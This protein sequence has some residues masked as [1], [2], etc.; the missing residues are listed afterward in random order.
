MENTSP[1]VSVFSL[2]FGFLERRESFKDML[3]LERISPHYLKATLQSFP[4]LH[5]QL[6]TQT[7]AEVKNCPLTAWLGIC[8]LTGLFAILCALK[9]NN[10]HH[11]HHHHH[12]SRV[13]KDLVI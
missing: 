9:N 7:A 2:M 11:H 8:F 4:V 3:Q 5:F 12:Q 13:F 10:H 6:S 1:K